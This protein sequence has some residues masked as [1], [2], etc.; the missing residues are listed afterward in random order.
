MKTKCLNEM[1]ERTHAIVLDKGDEVMGQLSELVKRLAISSGKFSG[2]GAFESVVIGFFDRGR[3]DY[4]RIEIS[5]QLEVLSLTGNIAMAE[6]E[7]KLHI[8]VVLGKSDGTAWGGHLLEAKVWPTLGVILEELPKHLRRKWDPE[9][10]LPLI[11]PS[12]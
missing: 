8:H 4:K 12:L 6:G 10:K 5:E 7:P 2:L 9:T 3:K 11:D 1:P